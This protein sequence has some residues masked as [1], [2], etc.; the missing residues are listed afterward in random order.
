MRSVFHEGE[1]EVQERAGVARMADRLGNAIH[2]SLP[3]A[4]QDFLK[5]QPMAILA[6][7]DARGAVWSSLLWGEPGFMQA[8]DARTVFLDAAPL[9]G[10]PLAQ[11]SAFTGRRATGPRS[12]T[13]GDRT[14]NQ[15]T[16][17]GEWQ[18]KV[19]CRWRP[20][21]ACRTSL[22]QL[23]QVHSDADADV[24]RECSFQ[25]RSHPTQRAT[26]CRTTVVDRPGRHFF[27]RQYPSRRRG[28][29]LASRWPAR[30]HSGRRREITG[31]SRLCG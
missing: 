26:L 19:T 20:Q 27:H 6:Y 25:G 11:S 18:G 30:L 1:R 7:A 2:S 12:R 5:E 21:P 16:D 3:P 29:L 31:F 23:S 9:P 10:D 14:G 4:A 17:A 24:G 15:K 13:A 28:G 8:I 22:C